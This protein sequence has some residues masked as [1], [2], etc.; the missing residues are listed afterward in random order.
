LRRV[1]Q[2][3]SSRPLVRNL[4]AHDSGT[5]LAHNRALAVAGSCS[6]DLHGSVGPPPTERLGRALAAFHRACRHLERFHNA[7]TLA[8]FRGEDYL[9]RQAQAE[10]KLG[11]A[12]LVRADSGLPPGEVGPLPVVAG[13]S[14]RS[15]IEPRLGRVASSLAGKAVEVRCWSQA[16]WIRLLCTGSTTAR[17]CRRI[18]RPSAATAASTTSV[19]RH[20]PGLSRADRHVRIHGV[21]IRVLAVREPALGV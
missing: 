18:A 2:I 5:I 8:V 11:G 16:D 7:M 1:A 10:A 14:T 4:L 9:L 3:E 20:P 17:S 13:D 15:R 6:A 12:L 19:R 21:P